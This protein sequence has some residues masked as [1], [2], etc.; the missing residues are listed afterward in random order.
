MF[1]K[2]RHDLVAIVI[3]PRF[4][5]EGV[6]AAGDGDFAV[7]DVVFLEGCHRVA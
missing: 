2:I 4:F 6:V 3:D 7:F 1:P 5:A